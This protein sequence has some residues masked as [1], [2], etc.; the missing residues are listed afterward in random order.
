MGCPHPRL[1]V[2]QPAGTTKLPSP[3]NIIGRQH[4]SLVAYSNSASWCKSFRAGAELVSTYHFQ[5]LSRWLGIASNYSCEI[6]YRKGWEPG[7][8]K[9]SSVTSG[10][11]TD[12]RYGHPSSEQLGSVH[13]IVIRKVYLA[14]YRERN[15]IMLR[16]GGNSFRTR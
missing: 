10:S 11:D 5:P 12:L 3:I 14:T 6:G 7:E 8:A 15:F 16:D 4:F 13:I 1:T 2:C 9:L